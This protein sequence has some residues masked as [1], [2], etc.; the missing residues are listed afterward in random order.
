MKKEL[1]ERYKVEKYTGRK[2]INKLIISDEI[3]KY[4]IKT[5]K[6]LGKFIIPVK[7]VNK[8]FDLD[9]NKPKCWRIAK[10]LNSDYP[11]KGFIWKIGTEHKSTKYSVDLVEKI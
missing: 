9:I 10:K 7:D 4:L 8:D 6:E 3:V 1:K 2:Y 11:V 5:H